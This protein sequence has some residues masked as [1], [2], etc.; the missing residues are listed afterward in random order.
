MN[1]LEP[2]KRDS[3]DGAR[4]CGLCFVE[5]HHHAYILPCGHAFH[6]ICDVPLLEWVVTCRNS[7]RRATCPI[8]RDVITPAHFIE[9]IFAEILFSS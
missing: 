9:R 1:Y 4:E 7:R 8:C 5:I 2:F 3:C 6:Q